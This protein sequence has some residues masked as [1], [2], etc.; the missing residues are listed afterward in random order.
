[1]KQLKESI[2]L[3]LLLIALTG[4]AQNP[5]LDN[6]ISV[7]LENNFGVK[8]QNQNI[9]AVASEKEIIKGEATSNLDVMY[10]YGVSPIETRNGPIDHK[11]SAGIMLPWFG[12]RAKQYDVVNHK[13]EKAE[14]QKHQTEN[15]VKYTVRALYFQMLQ[16]QKDLGSARYNFEILK[17]FESIA[18]TQYENAKGS[19]VDVL[20]VQMQ[21]EE[22]QNK[23][24]AL[25]ADS[26]L[27]NQQFG[28]VLN[29]P[30]GKIELSDQLIFNSDSSS[31]GNNPLLLELEANQKVVNAEIQSVAKEASPK[32]KIALDYSII[33]NTQMQSD[34][35]GNNAVM[36][37]VGLSIPVFNAKKY[38][39]RKEQLA[40]NNQSIKLQ[41]QELE[42]ALQSEYLKAQNQREDAQRDINLIDQQ[43][44]K[45]DQAIK[46]Q[47]EIY[48]VGQNTQGSAFIE[49]LRLQMQRLE[50]QFKIH[51]AEQS[52]NDALAKI[53][54][55]Q[56][57]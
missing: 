56:G 30:T 25:I 22:A 20:R 50:Y 55:L 2:T 54:F 10:G 13:V 52:K 40:L 51:K 5:F 39:G 15:T 6:Y 37:M 11:V 9:Q 12:T 57:V 4:N 14:Q 16:N 28:L 38:N 21:I 32:I 1:M 3:V 24:N 43:I 29:H 8:A 31:L 34:N 19:L 35:A 49:L 45:V 42:N 23:I 48:T 46:I 33:G 26:T 17:S 36:P 41:K 47:R 7:A 18:L 44:A 27:F 53:D